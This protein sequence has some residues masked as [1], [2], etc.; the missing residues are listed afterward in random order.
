MQYSVSRF[1]A[2]FDSV[3]NL[4]QDLLLDMRYSTQILT[5]S[6]A[7]WSGFESPGMKPLPAPSLTGIADTHRRRW[8]PMPSP[9]ARIKSC[10]FLTPAPCARI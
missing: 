7:R 3:F 4:N 5:A 6:G 10:A 9:G 8:S 1:L 2:M